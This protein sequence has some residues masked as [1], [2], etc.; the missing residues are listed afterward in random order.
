MDEMPLHGGESHGFHTDEH[1]R[2]W[3]DALR[4]KLAVEAEDRVHER[5]DAYERRILALEAGLRSIA[6][7]QPEIVTADNSRA[8]LIDFIDLAFRVLHGRDPA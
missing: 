4:K 1:D 7:I 5:L 8:L 6:I 3:V 2:Q